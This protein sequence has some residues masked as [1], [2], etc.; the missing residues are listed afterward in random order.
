MGLPPSAVPPFPVLMARN[1]RP[2]RVVV[3][4]GQVWTALIGQR[5][6]Q[7]V[8][9]HDPVQD[10]PASQLSGQRRKI[11]TPVHIDH[12]AQVGLL[13]FRSET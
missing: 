6:A 5:H 11:T 4:A 8:C 10:H 2:A 7:S 12:R 3:D 13:L 9:A 1:L